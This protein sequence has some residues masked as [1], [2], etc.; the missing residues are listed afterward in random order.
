MSDNTIKFY[1]DHAAEY[2][3][4]K[5]SPN[6]KLS[7]FLKRCRTGGKI[8]E[9]GTGAGVDAQAILDAGFLLDATDGSSE[10]AAIASQRLGQTVKVMRFTELAAQQAYDGIYAC[11]S[12]THAQKEDLPEILKRIHDAL[13]VGGVVWASFKTGTHDGTDSFGRY[14]NYP[15]VDEILALWRDAG[16]WASF[17]YECS[18]GKGYDEKPIKWASVTAIK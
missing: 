7:P 8:L 3:S 16:R 9:L 6:S 10:L 15:S 2:A 11:A 17:D 14:Y 18:E 5:T 1:Q 12:L 4:Y 13:K